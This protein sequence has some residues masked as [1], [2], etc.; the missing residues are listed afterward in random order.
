MQLQS[1]QRWLIKKAT[2]V[3]EKSHKCELL[4][5]RQHL[6]TLKLHFCLGKME[7]IGVTTDAVNHTAAKLSEKK[8]SSFVL[9]PFRSLF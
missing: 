5:K 1:Y 4:Y 3:F 8:P 9:S 7:N 2:K 6:E